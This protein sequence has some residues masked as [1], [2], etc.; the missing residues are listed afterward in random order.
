MMSAF[1]RGAVLVPL[2]ALG[3]I[4]CDDSMVPAK[5]PDAGAPGPDAGSALPPGALT[6]WGDMAPIFN[7]KCNKCHQGGGIAPFRLDDYASAERVAPMIQFMTETRRMPPYLL[8]HDGSCGDLQ[9]DETLT[10]GEIAKIKLWV[11]G[12]RHEG[13]K[14]TLVP[15]V[16][17]AL[18]GGTEYKTPTL[19]P[20][21]QGGALAEFDEYR[22]FPIETNLEKDRFI[23]GYE[24]LPGNP[25]I[26]HHVLGFLIDPAKVTPTGKTNAEL[27]KELD[28]R[29]PDRIG[30]P[31]FGMAGPG[32]VL[33]SAPVNWAPGT[34][35]VNFPSGMGI[36][37]RKNQKLVVQLHYNLADPKNKGMSDTTTVR[38]LHTDKVEQRLVF[39]LSDA[40]LDSLNNPKPDTIPPG[41]PAAQYVWKMKLTEMG[42]PEQLPFVD[43]IGVG[44]HMH[45]RG[46]KNKLEI[47]SATG[48]ACVARLERWDFNWQKLYFYRTP[49][50]LLPGNTAQITCEYDT[51]ADVNPVSPGWGTRNEMCLDAMLVALPK[52]I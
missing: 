35:V 25:A 33:D 11:E 13:T 41:M 10:D 46:R 32:I 7:A 15:P 3:A 20:V 1:L 52:G 5:S 17:P 27:M 2:I 44:P 42:L 4:G 16:V 43:L 45:Q 18:V 31:C 12:G 26:V 37:H 23:T 14:V 47:I 40:L 24:V 29:D 28:D 30:W 50:T 51:A 9:A 36:A 48:T 19:A 38:L 8:T 22:C 34:G 6:F 21:A 49:I 39:L